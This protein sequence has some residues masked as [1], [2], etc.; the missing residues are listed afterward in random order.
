MSE[1]SVK[2][3]VVNGELFGDGH[4][5]NNL[6]SV[7]RER[8]SQLETKARSGARLTLQELGDAIALRK[9]AATGQPKTFCE[10]VKELS[11]EIGRARRIA[12]GTR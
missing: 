3:G 11:S 2:G 12:D 4:S 5:K 10:R 8:A 7:S 1:F 6:D 9:A